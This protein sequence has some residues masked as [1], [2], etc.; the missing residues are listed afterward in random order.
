MKTRYEIYDLGGNIT[1]I[2]PEMP[3][4]FECLTIANKIMQQNPNVEQV[5]VIE[6]VNKN[7]CTFKMVGGEFCGNACRAVAEFMRRNFGFEKSKIIINGM[8]INAA[9]N[10][11]TSEINIA[12]NNLVKETKNINGQF[13]VYMNGITQIII[14]QNFKNNLQKAEEMII[15]FEKF[16]NIQDA[17]GIMFLSGNKIDPFVWVVKAKTFFNETACLSGSIAAALFLGETDIVQPTGET[18]A[19]KFNKR[20]I[21]ASGKVTFIKGGHA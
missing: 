9:S 14:P 8:K 21:K 6:K 15:D 19:I 10:G 12:K 7:V 20:F 17:L 18:Y 1:A 5:A 13:C 11:E 4:N 16:N 3:N 2:I